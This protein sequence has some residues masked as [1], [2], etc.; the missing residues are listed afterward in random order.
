MS[1]YKV[2]YVLGQLAYATARAEEPL[3]V[4]DRQKLHDLFIEYM[5]DESIELDFQ[6]LIS[7]IMDKEKKGLDTTYNWAIQSLKLEQNELNKETKSCFINLLEKVITELP[8][9]GTAAK[10]LPDRLRNEL[11]GE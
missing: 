8:S 7:H 1:S 9:Q 6:E 4:V 10:D 5:S 11:Q 2:Y 3:S